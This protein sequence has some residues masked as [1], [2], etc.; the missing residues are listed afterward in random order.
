M[1]TAKGKY[2]DIV[3]EEGEIYAI[4]D[5]AL[6][7]RYEKMKKKEENKVEDND[8]YSYYSKILYDKFNVSEINQSLYITIPKRHS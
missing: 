5:E 7:F 6:G 4:M 1:E 3:L 2:K 8:F